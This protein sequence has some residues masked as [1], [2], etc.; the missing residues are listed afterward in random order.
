MTSLLREGP[1]SLKVFD[2][3]SQHDEHVCF[4][5]NIMCLI[6]TKFSTCTNSSAVGA[7]AKFYDDVVL[8]FDVTKQHICA[9]F[10]ENF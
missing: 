3:T 6:T 9:K 4:S 2:N 5:S 7:C 8:I 10:C 1:V